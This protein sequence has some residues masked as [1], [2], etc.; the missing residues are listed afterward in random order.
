LNIEY[1]RILYPTKKISYTVEIYSEIGSEPET[2]TA[3]MWYAENIGL[4]KFE[5]NQFIVNIGGGGIIFDPSSN[6]L[7]QELIGYSIAE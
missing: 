2:F 5:G 4:V 3:Y 1:V 7:T 6:I